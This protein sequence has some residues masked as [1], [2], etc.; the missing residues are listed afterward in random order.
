M[1]ASR[2][3]TPADQAQQVGGRCRDVDYTHPL[4]ARQKGANQ[5]AR[6]ENCL[7]CHQRLVT[8]KRDYWKE[9]RFLPEKALKKEETAR[10]MEEQKNKA[11]RAPPRR[12]RSPERAP[13]LEQMNDLT[14]KLDP[15]AESTSRTCA[16]AARGSAKGLSPQAEFFQHMWTQQTQMP[17]ALQQQVIALTG[18]IQQLAQTQSEETRRNASR[19]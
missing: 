17:Q 1:V 16:S 2:G 12:H 14:R 19:V 13:T 6:C 10:R 5:C 7:Q 9:A 4:S 3:A 18:A 8:E 11:I 15:G